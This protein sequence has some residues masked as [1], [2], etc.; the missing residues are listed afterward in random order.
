M[1][2]ARRQ[3]H[4]VASAAGVL[5]AMLSAGAGLGAC[6]RISRVSKGGVTATERATVPPSV[7]RDGRDDRQDA[8][9]GDHG[10]GYGLGSFAACLSKGGVKVRVAFTKDGRPLLDTQ[11]VSMGSERVRIAWERCR[12]GVDLGNAFGRHEGKLRAGDSG[13]L[14]RE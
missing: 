14:G 6:G 3:A 8:D 9:H 11:G 10:A 13:P 1:M 12:A 2:H 7:L 5:A 4:R